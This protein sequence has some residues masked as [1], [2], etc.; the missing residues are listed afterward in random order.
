MA[1]AFDRITGVLGGVR[2]RMFVLLLVAG[3][4]VTG[5]AIASALGDYRAALEEGRRGLVAH[6]SA[7]A[8]RQVGQIEAGEA[9]LRT[10]ARRDLIDDPACPMVLQQAR[11]LQALPFADLRILREDG[12]TACTAEGTS[13]LSPD[14][15]LLAFVREAGRHGAPGGAIF[16]PGDDAR[17][18]M[19]PLAVPA[20]AGRPGTGPSNPG[21]RSTI[22][23]TVALRDLLPAVD[24][25]PDGGVWL[26]DRG[27]RAVALRPAAVGTPPATVIEEAGREAGVRTASDG[28]AYAGATLRP[29]LRLIV[30]QPAA[31]L[32]RGANAVLMQRI[33]ELATF[34]LL[35]L[36]AILVG[37]D[38]TMVRPLR[39]L[40]DR[41]RRWHPGTAFR[42][43]PPGVEPR[44]V[45][46]VELAF[47]ASAAALTRREAELEAALGQRDALMAEIHHRVK[48]NLQ[49]VSSLL[50]LQAGRIKDP[51]AAGEF[52]AARNRVR[53][54]ATLHRHLYVEKSFE[55]VLLRPFITE[56]ANGVFTSH[57]ESPGERIT[58]RLDVADLPISVDQA[59]SLALFV[60]EALGNAVEHGFP[61]ETT[62]TVR[63]RVAEEDGD[64][65][66][67]AEDDGT[68]LPDRASRPRGLGLTLM[69]GFAKQ[70][71]GPLAG[72]RAEPPGVGT[73]W[74]V[75]FPLRTNAG[76]RRM[77]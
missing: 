28:Y 33:A 12:T 13:F 39:V 56:L 32:E 74:S 43:A 52:L 30:G 67:T 9:L 42:P 65:I 63:L 73:R 4:P 37:A 5:M 50:N 16:L 35:C 57:N 7:I 58:L 68:G 53:A 64:A 14:P 23:G 27:G 6:R 51:E 21:P 45:R 44:E 29:G 46:E 36:I 66:V 11:D 10:L 19:I 25:T 20:R 54:L 2:G 76:P 55:R 31:L 1:G 22:L 72:G 15:A 60:T 3:I 61:D 71:G 38:L 75:R 26:V 34:L 18:W 47:A 69:E 17:G 70:L 49:I 48:N 40:S 59:V 8:A 62:G 24:G 41:V 77:A